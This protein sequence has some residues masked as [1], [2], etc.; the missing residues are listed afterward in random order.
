[1][2]DFIFDKE[3]KAM[4]EMNL[5]EERKFIMMFLTYMYL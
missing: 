2:F 3:D 5:I 1:M 4:R